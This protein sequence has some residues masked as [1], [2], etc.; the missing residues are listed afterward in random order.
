MVADAVFDTLP[1]R[2][3]RDV[4][5]AQEQG[6]AALKLIADRIQPGLVAIQQD[7]GAGPV[8]GQ[9]SR[10]GQADAGGGAGDQDHTGGRPVRH[11][12]LRRS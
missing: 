11:G 10:G 5:T 4:L 6:G 1:F 8:G 3:V 9:P 7:Q 2:F 12:G